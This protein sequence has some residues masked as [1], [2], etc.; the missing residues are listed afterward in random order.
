MGRRGGIWNL[1]DLFNEEGTI[2]LNWG[3]PPYSRHIYLVANKIS[4]KQTD[5]VAA[6]WWHVESRY[7]SEHFFWTRVPHYTDV[8]FH[9]DA[10]PLYGP[11]ITILPLPSSGLNL[12]LTKCIPPKQTPIFNFYFIIILVK[13]NNN[14]IILLLFY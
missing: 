7:F 5:D 1:L 12:Y 6:L 2:G 10:L 8:D 13:N 4:S 3:F 9:A 14:I 11:W